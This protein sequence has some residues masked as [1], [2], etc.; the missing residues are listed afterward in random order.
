[1]AK[2]R[3]PGTSGISL[4]KLTTNLHGLA[5]T[6]RKYVYRYD[7]KVMGTTNSGREVELTKRVSGE[8]VSS[9]SWG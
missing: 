5:M 8:W 9:V 4:G 7:V 1:M 3:D 2:K 6:Q